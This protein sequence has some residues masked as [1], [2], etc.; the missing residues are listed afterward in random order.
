[1]QSALRKIGR[2]TKHFSR[3][4]EATMLSSNPGSG[5]KVVLN[6]PVHLLERTDSAA[7]LLHT[8]RSKLIREAVEEKIG[9]IERK[10]LSRQRKAAYAALGESALA[11]NRE[12]ED[13]QL[14][15]LARTEF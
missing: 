8:D 5:K 4:R 6:F 10:E 11:L 7:D 9:Q 3:N 15:V 1:M 12:F 2:S 13:A 14:A